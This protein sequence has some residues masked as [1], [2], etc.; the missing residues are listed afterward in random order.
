MQPC[1]T[2]ALYRPINYGF[3]TIMLGPFLLCSLRAS[4]VSEVFC[5]E[6]TI[7]IFCFSFCKHTNDL[8]WRRL[9]VI[10]PVCH[11][12]ACTL[13]TF[14]WCI[15]AAVDTLSAFILRTRALTPSY[16]YLPDPTHSSPT[17][18]DLTRRQSLRCAT[19]N[20]TVHFLT[21]FISRRIVS[22]ICK[23]LSFVWR[24]VDNLLGD[25]SLIID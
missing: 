8:I 18:V 13:T 15:A 3:D 22:W 9:T 10:E 19:L 14:K 4:W 2:S 11:L 5:Y 24:D 16:T 12:K 25:L 6:D 17:K 23:D 21:L 1:T 20:Y 7:L